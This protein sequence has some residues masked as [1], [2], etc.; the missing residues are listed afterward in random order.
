[1]ERM[2][3]DDAAKLH[4]MDVEVEKAAARLNMIINVAAFIA[5]VGAIRVGELCMFMHVTVL[6]CFCGLVTRV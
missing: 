3:P 5:I 2:N 4:Q 1:M 6:K